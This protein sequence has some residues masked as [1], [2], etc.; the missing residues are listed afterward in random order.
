[1]FKHLFHGRDLDE[2][3][4]RRLTVEMCVEFDKVKS[5]KQFTN[6]LMVKIFKSDVIS[7]AIVDN[8]PSQI[9]FLEP[10][11]QK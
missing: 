9:M 4:D 1:M 3:D 8:A 10:F 6:L 11:T 7:L 2:N 5:C